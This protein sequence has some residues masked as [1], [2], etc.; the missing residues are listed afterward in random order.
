MKHINTHDY[1][2]CVLP[3]NK[4]QGGATPVLPNGSAATPL[5][6]VAAAKVFCDSA[7]FD[8]SY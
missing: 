6:V 4:L 3:L 5:A 8:L 1:K 7:R 2:F